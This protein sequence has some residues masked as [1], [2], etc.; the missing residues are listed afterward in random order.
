MRGGSTD[1]PG[2]GRRGEPT[3]NVAE[4]KDADPLVLDGTTFSG[5]LPGD[6][7]QVE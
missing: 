7:H 4:L 3:Y 2:G 1:V 5:I 6:H